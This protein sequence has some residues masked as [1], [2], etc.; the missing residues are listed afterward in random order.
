VHLWYLAAISLQPDRA[1]F[2]KTAVDNLKDALKAPRDKWDAGFRRG[3]WAQTLWTIA[4]AAE[5]MFLVEWFYTEKKSLSYRPCP[6][7]LD[8]VAL[9]RPPENRA[10]LALL[11]RDPRF[12][13]LDWESLDRMIRVLNRWTKQ[14]IVADEERGNLR[15]PNAMR[16][17]Q[18]AHVEEEEMR[19][20]DPKDVALLNK[21]LAQWRQ[22]VRDSVPEWIAAQEKAK[23]GMRL[24]EH[25][26]GGIAVYLD[27]LTDERT[28][29]TTAEIHLTEIQR[30]DRRL[31]SV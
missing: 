26:V 8:H 9:H 19:R 17:D 1:E 6:D 27:N 21:T 7:F 28:L 22:K 20:F 11:V 3:A 13:K 25:T 29:A 24:K 31:R 10:M 14:P 5:S 15:G 12:D 30:G 16:F 18:W 23:I 4:G 2:R